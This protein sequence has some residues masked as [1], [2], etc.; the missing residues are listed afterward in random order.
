MSLEVFGVETKRKK[1]IKKIFFKKDLFHHFFIHPFINSLN[2]YLI[3]SLFQAEY[4]YKGYLGWQDTI[5]D[6]KYIVNKERWTSKL[7][8]LQ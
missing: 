3:L 5:F 4:G 8:M 6:K 1:Q 2:I 7:L